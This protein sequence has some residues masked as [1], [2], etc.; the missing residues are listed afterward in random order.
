[1]RFSLIQVNRLATLSIHE[2]LLNHREIVALRKSVRALAAAGNSK[3][4]IDLSHATHVNSPLI[5]AMVEIHVRYRNLDGRVICVCPP[6]STRHL[7]HVLKLDQL[8]EITP[9]LSEAIDRLRPPH[10]SPHA[11][12]I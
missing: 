8:L 1:M 11:H 2:G 3:L 12:S 10:P 4:I 7:F 5:G 6:D 9:S